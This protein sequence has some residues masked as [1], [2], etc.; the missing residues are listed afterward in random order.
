MSPIPLCVIIGSGQR[1]FGFHLAIEGLYVLGRS[2]ALPRDDELLGVWFTSSQSSSGRWRAKKEKAGLTGG[3]AAVHLRGCEGERGEREGDEDCGELRGGQIARRAKQNEES[4]MVRS[5]IGWANQSGRL[6]LMVLFPHPPSCFL[7]C[8]S[9]P[10]PP[11][12]GVALWLRHQSSLVSA[13]VSCLSSPVLLSSSRASTD[14][15]PVVRPVTSPSPSTSSMP[16]TSFY[17]PSSLSLFLLPADGCWTLAP[18]TRSSSAPRL[19]SSKS[20]GA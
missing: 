18:D 1:T 6:I 13:F 19:T 9:E 14:P 20:T 17:F 15:Q 2:R 8:R 10:P 16:G 3:H 11:S 12:R 4:V 5:Q 7:D